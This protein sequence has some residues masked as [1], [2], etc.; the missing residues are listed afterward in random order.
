MLC[1]KVATVAPTTLEDYK[2]HQDPPGI[3]GSLIEGRICYDAFVL[4]KK[5]KEIYYQANKPAV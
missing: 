2:V 5:A 1:H 3:N 4:E